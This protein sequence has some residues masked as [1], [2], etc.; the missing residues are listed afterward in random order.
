MGITFHMF[1]YKT[2]EITYL[3]HLFLK[4][5]RMTRWMAKS[6]EITYLWLYLLKS[7]ILLMNVWQNLGVSTLYMP[8]TW[9][10]EEK[11]WKEKH[12]KICVCENTCIW[13]W[14]TFYLNSLQNKDRAQLLNLDDLF[15]TLKKD[16]N[17]S[18]DIKYLC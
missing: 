9:I 18:K 14:K 1:C 10:R 16:L 13:L 11:K 12:K 17:K 6:V 3:W 15:E 4:T 5:W 2:L 7:Y 8:K